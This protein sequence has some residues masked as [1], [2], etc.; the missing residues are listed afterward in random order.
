MFYRQRFVTNSSS[1]S[2]IFFGVKFSEVDNETIIKLIPPEKVNKETYSEEDLTEEFW[3]WAGALK[4]ET[5]M[6]YRQKFITNSSSTSFI[7]W[8]YVI[9]E[10]LCSKHGDDDFMDIL[11]EGG[12]GV[13]G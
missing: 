9:P 4:G 1:T 10:E 11:Y 13:G 3:S 12:P 7:A 6:F 5:I 2:F 8:G